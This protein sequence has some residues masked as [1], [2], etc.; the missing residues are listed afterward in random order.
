M[1]R[2]CDA[3]WWGERVEYKQNNIKLDPGKKVVR[4]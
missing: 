3:Y 2:Q 4:V 1:K